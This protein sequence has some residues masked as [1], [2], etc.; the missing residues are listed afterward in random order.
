V[1]RTLSAP[2]RSRR[3]WGSS[4]ASKYPN[5]VEAQA[6]HALML[7]AMAP[8]G[9]QTFTNQKAAGE[10]LEKLWVTHP[11]HP[12]LPH[13]IIHA[14]DY[15][16]GARR[17]RS[18]LCRLHAGALSR[19]SRTRLR[20]SSL[21]LRDSRARRCACSRRP[22]TARTPSA[23]TWSRR[24]RRSRHASSWPRCSSRGQGR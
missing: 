23:Q 20:V 12:G 19:F 13:Y 17:R 6:F 15:A 10:V 22:P 3:P 11:D 18:R 8:P 24:A 1:C 21:R 14:Y 9:D 16:R 4:R 5:D 7:L 2:R